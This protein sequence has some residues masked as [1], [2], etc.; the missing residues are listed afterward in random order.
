MAHAPFQ[1]A[2][3]RVTG[4]QASARP[5]KP[6]GNRAPVA[7]APFQSAG[8]RVTGPR[9]RPLA[10]TSPPT[11]VRQWHTLRFNQAKRPF[12]TISL[13]KSKPFRRTFDSVKFNPVE[14]FKLC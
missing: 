2:G 7:H 5:D 10:R 1:S 9:K 6:A 4:P 11:I 12:R 13:A 3:V 14:C 8:V